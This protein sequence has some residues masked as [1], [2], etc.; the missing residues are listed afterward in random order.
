MGCLKQGSCHGQPIA[1]R[2][3]FAMV[4]SDG[5]LKA[6]PHIL[7]I[8]METNQSI[9][10]NTCWDNAH[11]RQQQGNRPQLCPRPLLWSST[12][13]E[14]NFDNPSNCSITSTQTNNFTEQHKSC[15]WM[16]CI[17]FSASGGREAPSS[18]GAVACQRVP[19]GSGRFSRLSLL[20]LEKPLPQWNPG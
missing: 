13:P 4:A 5:N 10:V 12:I 3:R 6:I 7:P 1:R 19:G 17:P 16:L 2:W 14:R 18:C 20:W 9:S 8:P 15:T 11:F